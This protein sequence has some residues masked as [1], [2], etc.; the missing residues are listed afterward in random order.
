VSD[1]R[2]APLF[3]AAWDLCAWVLTRLG[4]DRSVLPASLCSETL[5]LLDAV[6]LALKDVDRLENLSQADLCLIRLRM[7]V[8]LAAETGLLTERQGL[9]LL[10]QCDDIGRQ[11]GGW[12][13]S[14]DL[15]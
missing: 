1:R 11:L 12:M 3:T 4:G 9:F 2:P 8:R 14:L 10:G 6:V 13:K 5:A 15:A 7:R